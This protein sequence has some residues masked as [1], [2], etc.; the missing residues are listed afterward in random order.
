[1]SDPT[2]WMAFA[3]SDLGVAATPGPGIS[4]RVHKYY[5]DAGHPEIAGDDV[6]WCAAFVGACLER[7]GLRSTRSLMA[8]SYLSYG[9]AS[10]EG[11]SGAIAVFSRDEDPALGHV[12]FVVGETSDAIMLLGGNQ[13]NAVSVITMPKA[14]LLGLRWPASSPPPIPAPL[15][16][17]REVNPGQSFQQALDHVLLMEGGYTDDPYDPGGPTNLGITL[18]DLASYRGIA[19]TEATAAELKSAV[20]GLTPDAVAPIYLSRYWQPSCA[21]ALPSALALFHFDTAVNQ[22]ISAAARMLQQALSVDVDGEIG[23]LTLAAAASCDLS[24]TLDRY[25]ELRRDRYRA[26]STFWRF[27]KGWLARVDATRTAA[28]ILSTT[29]VPPRTASK[30]PPMT[31]NAPASSTPVDTSQPKWWG[32]SITIWGAIVTTLATVLSVVGPIIGLQISADV[33]HQIGDGIVQVVQALAG[34]IGILMTVYG[35]TR[36][37]QPLVRREF[38]VKL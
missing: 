7:A 22:G 3:W 4:A 24:I 37:V 17:D 38:L 8:R 18:A 29:S 26:L 12:G 21:A 1:M 5:A 2:P 13:S 33:V 6:A 23:P 30:E 27:G 10:P 9:S 15:P 31:T 11:R 16:A 35:R 19:I 32:Q 34:V 25:A 36:A 28:A 20:K 14:R